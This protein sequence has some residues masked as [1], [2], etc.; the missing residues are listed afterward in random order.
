VGLLVLKIR[1]L[2]YLLAVTL[3]FTGCAPSESEVLKQMVSH[4]DGKLT[5][6]IFSDKNFS[7]EV[8]KVLNSEPAALLKNIDGVTINPEIDKI[9]WLKALGLKEE[10]PVILIF[11]TKK[12]VFHSND[13]EKLREF[14]KSLAN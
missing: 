8:N 2:L 4:K 3:I 7:F 14:A 6:H 9:K 11:D 5:M 10:R 12:L 1:F 13:P